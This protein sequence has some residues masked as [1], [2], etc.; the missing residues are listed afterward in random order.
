MSLTYGLEG[1]VGG[2]AAN[3]AWA[4]VHSGL[5]TYYNAIKLILWTILGAVAFMLLAQVAMSVLLA[6]IS[7]IGMGLLVLVSQIMMMVG[8]SRMTAVPRETGAA[9]IMQVA[10]IGF[11]LSFVVAVLAIIM[12]YSA[13]SLS[14][15]ETLG[16]INIA[17]GLISLVA[18]V[19]LLVALGRIARS[20]GRADLSGTSM[21]LIIMMVTLIGSVF[22][23]LLAPR[24]FYD[25]RILY[26]IGLIVLALVFLVMFMGLVSNTRDA[27]ASVGNLDVDAF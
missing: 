1:Q 6:Q 8:L 11:V 10:F 22:V 7:A 26:F 9:G 25:I 2:G 15:L 27:V 20:V 5:S 17:R 21:K 3:P 24:L 4:R 23:P 12:Q 16:Y 18:F 14:D 13:S 19:C